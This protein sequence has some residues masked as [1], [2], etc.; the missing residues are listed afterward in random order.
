VRAHTHTHSR[1]HTHTH[2]HTH[3]SPPPPPPPPHAH[4]YSLSFKVSSCQ[5]RSRAQSFCPALPIATVFLSSSA[6]RSSAKVVVKQCRSSTACSLNRCSYAHVPVCAC[7]CPVSSLT[8]MIELARKRRETA[9]KRALEAEASKKKEMDE[10]AQDGGLRTSTGASVGAAGAAEDGAATASHIGGTAQTKVMP[11]INF[12][13]LRATE[14]SSRASFSSTHC[15]IVRMCVL[16]IASTHKHNSASLSLPT[17]TT[18]TTPPPTPT[19]TQTHTHNN[20]PPPTPTHTHTHVRT[21]ASLSSNRRGKTRRSC[22]VPRP[23]SSFPTL[24]RRPS[25]LH[26]VPS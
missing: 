5:R 14:F 21:H 12:L 2:T 11:W 7:V 17:T 8:G 13:P 25:S 6:H 20:T 9:A 3:T 22:G 24:P 10:S 26:E 16:Q 1:T 23:Q 19:P 15:R 4:I 18:T